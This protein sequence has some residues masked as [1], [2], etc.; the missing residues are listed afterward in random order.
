[1]EK[2][3]SREYHDELRNK[4]CFDERRFNNFQSFSPSKPLACD[5]KT[6]KGKVLDNTIKNLNGS[7][8]LI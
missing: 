8:F 1:M 6:M 3:T 7:L 2:M 4:P 5:F